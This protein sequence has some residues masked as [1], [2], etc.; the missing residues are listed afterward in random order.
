MQ[1]AVFQIPAEHATAGAVIV[2]DQVDGEIF[3]EE[4]RIML[5]ALLIQGMQDRMAGPVS[6]S[7][8]TLHRLLAV[9][10]HMAAERPLIDLA[11][12]GA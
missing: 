2:H 3:D 5:Q 7:T 1:G 11:V 9:V 12:F 4:I 10:A 6:S 8:G